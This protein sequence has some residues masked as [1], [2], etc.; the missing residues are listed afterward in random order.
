MCGEPAPDCSMGR[1]F[2]KNEHPINAAQPPKIS[3][4]SQYRAM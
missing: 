4:L 3:N 2:E 1:D